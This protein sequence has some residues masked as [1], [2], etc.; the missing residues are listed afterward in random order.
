M[1][2]F[3]IWYSTLLV[4]ECWREVFTLHASC[5]K[6]FLVQKYTFTCFYRKLD[7]FHMH[8]EEKTFFFFFKGVFFCEALNF[9]G[10]FMFF[11]FFDETSIRP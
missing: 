11:F 1:S 2:R 5:E 10:I 3:E 8:G 4:K 6:C 9:L 7:I